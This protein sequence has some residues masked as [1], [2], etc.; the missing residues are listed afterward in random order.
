MRTLIKCSAALL[1][2]SV[3]AAAA[4]AAA[5]ADPWATLGLSRGADEAAI[6]R[7]Y[8]SLALKLHPDKV[9]LS[10][11]RRRPLWPLLPGLCPAAATC[12]G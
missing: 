9:R 3:L 1:A 10:C 8:R 6:K 4:A 7:A 12:P 2:F 5:A 11:R